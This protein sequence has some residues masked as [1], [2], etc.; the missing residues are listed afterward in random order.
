MARRRSAWDQAE[1]DLYLTSRT[2][3]DISAA[4]R[5]PAVLGTRL[6]RRSLTRTLF[7][8]LRGAAK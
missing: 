2:M 4:Q 5:G 7:S 3:K 8:L 6:A 1:R